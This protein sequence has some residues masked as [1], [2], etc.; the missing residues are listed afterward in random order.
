MLLDLLQQ[1]LGLEVVDHLLAGIITVHADIA[2]RD[3]LAFLRLV[4]PDGRVGGEDIDQPTV[5]LGADGDLVAMA[6]PYPVVVEVVRRGD[7]HAAGAELRVHVLLVGDDGD[8]PAG[9]RQLHQLPQQVLVTLIPRMDRHRAVAQHGLRAGGGHH[10]MALAV[11]QGVAHVPEVAA[12]LLGE[13]LQVGDRGVQ[14]RVPVDQT[15]ASVDQPLLEQADEH[16][17]DGLGETGVHG[18]ALPAPVQG[19][20]HAAQLA[21]DGAAGS[22]APFPHPLDEGIAAVVMPGPALGV[23]QTLHHHLGG[24]AGMVG[25]RLPQG[26]VALHAVVADQGI[27]DRVL[28]GVPHVQAARDVGRRDHDAVGRPSGLALGRGEVAPLLPGLVPALF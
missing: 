3:Q 9:E 21:G 11:A 23:D 18:E 12:L 17:L 16:L 8:A 10:Q 20:P 28:K 5:G 22:L 2:L 1:A 27:H 13:H 4:G 14:H 7:L 19:R 26:R 15:L 6:L 24:D 25:T